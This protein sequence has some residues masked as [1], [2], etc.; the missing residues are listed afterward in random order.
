MISGTGACVITANKGADGNFAPITSAPVN[1][2][3][4]PGSAPSAPT[5]LAA[6]ANA[7]ERIALTWLDT[8]T[9]ESG[10]RIER[11]AVKI[12]NFTEIATVGPNLTTYVD[13]TGL[14][15]G[16]KYFYRLRSF[17]GV[18]ASAYSN[19]TSVT[20][21]TPP[22]APSGLT[23]S[24]ITSS[25]ISLTWNDRSN[26]ELGFKIYRS[27][28]GIT[29]VEVAAVGV[30]V[31]QYS[32]TGLAPATA[33]SFRVVAYN[34]IGNSAPSNTV[35]ATTLGDASTP[36]AAPTGL[37][38][39]VSP[40][41]QITLRWSDNANNESGFTIERSLDG[42]S[43][44]PI[45]STGPNEASSATYTDIGLTASTTYQYRVRAFNGVGQSGYSNLASAKTKAR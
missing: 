30:N 16:T 29:F 14:S 23:T 7:S 39:T 45:A 15:A 4:T 20:T 18:G 42:V 1:V 32:D 26:N 9:T 10:F 44:S 27:P 34:A 2:T 19:T 28:D 12:N 5:N 35:S 24:Q 36:P 37:T 8:A 41:L 31:R 22:T 40:G 3:A 33:F 43:F 6:V 11:S 21:P 17:N 25:Q 38:A 13:D